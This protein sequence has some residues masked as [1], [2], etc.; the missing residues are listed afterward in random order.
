M[1]AALTTQQ[2]HCPT[3]FLVGLQTLLQ[4]KHKPDQFWG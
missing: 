4:Q 3:A 1:T 2:L